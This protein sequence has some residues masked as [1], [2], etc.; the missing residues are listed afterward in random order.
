MKHFNILFPRMSIEERA[1]SARRVKAQRD[2]Y[3]FIRHKNYMKKIFVSYY[4]VSYDILDLEDHIKWCKQNCT[5]DW[6]FNEN[7]FG[8]NTELDATFFTLLAK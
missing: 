4:S 7:W 3:K 5:N 2:F 1:L 8:F 6:V